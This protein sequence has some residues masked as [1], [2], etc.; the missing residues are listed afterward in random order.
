MQNSHKNLQHVLKLI[1]KV[2]ISTKRRN[3]NAVPIENT[4]HSKVAINSLK[5]KK[6]QQVTKNV[7]AQDKLTTTKQ[8]QMS[9]SVMKKMNPLIKES[10]KKTLK[11]IQ[12]SRKRIKAHKSLIMPPRLKYTNTG[13]PYGIVGDITSK[14]RIISKAATIPHTKTKTYRSISGGIL[15]SNVPNHVRHIDQLRSKYPR[16]KPSTPPSAFPMH[17]KSSTQRC[18]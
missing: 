10:Q 17:H 1:K 15:N 16:R 6:P 3:G 8:L 13:N 9:D 5:V 12:I 18:Y 4:V 7:L 11:D 2:I 14:S